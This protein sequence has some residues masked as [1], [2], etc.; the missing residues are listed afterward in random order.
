LRGRLYEHCIDYGA[1]PNERALTQGLKKEI[2]PDVV[3]FQIVYLSDDALVLRVCLKTAAQVGASVLGIFR[4]VFGERFDLTGLSD[5]L[6]RA[7]R[8][9]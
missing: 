8:G 7:R 1:H 9:L 5:E 4:L 6:T 2:G 3:K